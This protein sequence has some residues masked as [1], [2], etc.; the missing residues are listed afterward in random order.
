[1]SL[2]HGGTDRSLKVLEARGLVAQ[3]GAQAWALTPRGLAEAER[4]FGKGEEAP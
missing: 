3:V 1:M 4:T 2:G